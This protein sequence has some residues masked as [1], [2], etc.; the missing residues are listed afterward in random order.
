MKCPACGFSNAAGMNFCGQ[1]GG[2]LASVEG[3]AVPRTPDSN[4]ILRRFITPGLSEEIHALKGKI[5]GERRQVT[6]LFADMKGYTSLSEKLGEEAV[7]R[8]MDRIYECMINPVYQ[9]EGTVQQL[10]GDGMF[11][12]FGAPVAL[13]DAPLRACRAAHAIQERIRGLG[14]EFVSKHGFRPELR[15]GIHTG[16]VVLGAVGTDLKMDF[17]AVG[18]TVNLASRLET[19]AEPGGILMSEA[20]HTLVDGFVIGTDAGEREI[21]GKAKPQRV[22]VLDGLKEK[23]TRFDTAIQHGLTPFVGRD[24]EMEEL[25]RCCETACGGQTLLVQ[26]E[27]EAGIGKSRLVYEFQRWL[28]ET[29]VHFLKTHCTAFSKATSYL[30]FVELMRGIFVIEDKDGGQ[31]V[32]RKLLQG[33]DALGLVSENPVP[34][35]MAFLGFEVDMSAFK[36]MD[37]I[38]RG[39]RTRQILLE[40][41]NK[42]CEKTSMV[43]VIEDLHWMDKASEE[44]VGR[45]LDAKGKVPLLLL[46][47]YRP[48]E[49]TSRWKGHDAV[50]T[51]IVE[52]LSR[53]STM[54]MMQGLLGSDEVSEDIAETVIN[55]SECNPLF[56]EEVTRYLLESGGLKR[57]EKEVAYH[58]SS[59]KV[60]IPSSI[61]DLLQSRVDGLAEGPKGVLQTASVI[62]R[63]FSHELVR[64]VAGGNGS[65]EADLGELEAQDLVKREE[66]EGRVEYKFK[67]A[68]I[69]DAIYNNLLKDRK[70][71][72]HGSVAETIEA[73]YPER[74][75]EWVETLSFH[76]GN[77]PN[78]EKAVKYT[79]D[80]GEKSL[81]VYALDEA[82]QR[83]RR[84]VEL[85]ETGGV[86]DD[87]LLTDVVLSWVR[88]YFYRSE[89]TGLIEM[90]EK[91]LSRVEALDDKRRLSLLLFELGHAYNA[92]AQGGR[93]RELLERSK[94]LATEI[95]DEFCLARAYCGLV[96]SFA[97]TTPDPEEAEKGMEE[98]YRRGMALAEKNKD[99]FATYM[100]LLAMVAFALARGRFGLARRN[101]EKLIGTGRKYGDVRLVGS[102]MWMQSFTFLVEDNFE[103]A[104]EMA[105]KAY[106]VS[107]DPLDKICSL[108]SKGSALALMGKVREGLDILSRQ[109]LEL[110]R[111]GFLFPI[112]AVEIP[113]GAIMVMSGR[114][115]EGVQHIKKAI[116]SFL[117]TGNYTAEVNGDFFLGEIYTMMALGKAKPP[118][119][120]VLKNLGF[121]LKT[122]PFAEKKARH[123]LEKAIELS[124]R[125][126]MP[127]HR[128]KSYHRLGLLSMAKKKYGEALPYLE[129]ALEA[130]KASESEAIANTVQADLDAVREQ[131]AKTS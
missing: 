62:G 36:G 73:L 41:I 7:Y 109:R 65:F 64:R 23:A 25:A 99:H 86:E 131:T 42:Q 128:A 122:A 20:T 34:F 93:G 113:Y 5:E 88:V 70:E 8:L 120:V 126:D 59:S 27:G 53:Q 51:L 77:T 92:G 54:L 71:S 55:K 129:K 83:F 10:A 58:L 90:A 16:P 108:I 4:A 31:A 76:W 67:H 97:Y 94:A 22:Y 48:E 85:I 3:S 74:L 112:N 116:E 80:A 37:E 82:D 87:S 111:R 102:G 1:C 84:A 57:V 26:V 63:R 91:Y 78:V 46:C 95:G 13:E 60:D 52:P 61:V 28:E 103:M 9:E 96:W 47:S 106:P 38:R 81:K 75:G 89:F 115:G 104:L 29:H 39:E 11:A 12:L 49:Y 117:A 21:K 123:H 121:I 56:T 98:A 24:R 107:P 35:L 45:I 33:I 17:T 118:L 2:N 79:I 30:P 43:F 40:V 68:L 101:S 72:L 32:E 105:E 119:R 114:M 124:R 50:R 18:D 6:V 44:L 100:C 14:D 19:A 15:I 66:V 69:Q 127:G 130:A 110:Y 125:Y